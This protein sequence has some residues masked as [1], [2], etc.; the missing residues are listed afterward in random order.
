[1]IEFIFS[2]RF[3]IGLAVGMGIGLGCE[4]FWVSR[5]IKMIDKLERRL[6]NE[7]Y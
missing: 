6:N 5:S 3:L 1:M 7:Y 2:S 4:M